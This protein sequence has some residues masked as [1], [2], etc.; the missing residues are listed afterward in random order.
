MLQQKSLLLDSLLAQRT[1]KDQ[2]EFVG[3]VDQGLIVKI[4]ATVG[5]R[6]LKTDQRFIEIQLYIPAGR[7]VAA[8]CM[9][10]KAGRLADRSVAERP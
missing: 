6:G 9:A 1:M 5:T 4:V 10:V 2:A 8:Q 3:A 7:Q